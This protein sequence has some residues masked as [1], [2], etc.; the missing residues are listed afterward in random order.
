MFSNRMFLDK[1]RRRRSRVTLAILGY[2]D[3]TLVP[4]MDDMVWI[5][6]M[7]MYSPG[8]TTPT[9]SSSN[10]LHISEEVYAGLI[11]VREHGICRTP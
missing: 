9:V 10:N 3:F 1:I 6:Q 11:K 2:N 7:P 5:C 4:I 8:L